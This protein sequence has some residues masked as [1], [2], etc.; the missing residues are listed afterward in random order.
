MFV[1]FVISIGCWLVG[2]CD[3]ACLVFNVVAVGCCAL[4]AW[5]GLSAR[6]VLVWLLIG[7]EVVW[8][9]LYRF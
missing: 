6:G 5:F 1:I 7:F 2:C 3:I 4:S 9:V 8:F